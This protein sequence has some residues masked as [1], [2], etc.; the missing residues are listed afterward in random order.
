MKRIF[1]FLQQLEYLGGTETATISIAN[2]LCNEYEIT[3]VVTAKEPL[4][5]PYNI[6]KKIKILY[7]N[8]EDNSKIDEKIL[9]FCSE[10]KYFRAFYLILK[11]VHF[12]LIGKYKYRKM[13]K[14]M[15]TETDILIGSSLDNYLII[16]K[17]RKYIYHYHYN[18]KFFKTFNERFMS[19]FYRKADKY[20]FLN[21]VIKNDICKK[22]K[23]YRNLS[24][25]IQNPI[26]TK[27]S[28]NINY[29]NN[30]LVFLGRFAEQKNP[31]MLIE[32]ARIL[33][34]KGFKFNLNLY[35]DGKL[36][37]DIQESIKK[38]EL[39]NNVFIHKPTTNIEEVLK[40]SDLL[41]LTSLY[42]GTPLVIN[43]A[44]SQSVP[45]IT[46]N[47]GDSIKTCVPPNCG[48]I[49]ENF[50]PN[51]YANEIIRLLDNKELYFK[52]R[53]N[54]YNY[55]LSFSDKKIKEKRINLIESI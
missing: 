38:Y 11:N 17:K 50:N 25:F 37:K 31:L 52:Y 7:L 27:P 55:S 12:S 6:N 33:N 43:E 49:V 9:K 10:K 32:T 47:F 42:E 18:Y 20:V 14:K 24:L 4:K 22:Y 40:K 5:V 34:E 48:L 13:I 53:Q 16:P 2:L 1:W 51:I 39:M 36:L 29:Y 3:L 19:L 54:A 44:F 35:G 28:Q 21:E 23:F 26:K 30:T 8:N 45:C 15:T 41:L 46:T